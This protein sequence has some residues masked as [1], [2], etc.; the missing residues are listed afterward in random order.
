MSP[1]DRQLLQEAYAS[2]E[3]DRARADA[4]AA[5]LVRRNPDAPEARIAYAAARSRMQDYAAA[6][7]EL[8]IAAC[9]ADSAMLRFNLGYCH[10]QL[11]DYERAAAHLVRGLAMPG[12]DE[13][14]RALAADTLQIL[15]RRDQALSVIGQSDTAITKFCSWLLGATSNAQAREHFDGHPD[16]IDRAVLFWMK[17]DCHLF[18]ELDDKAALARLLGPALGEYWPKA[19]VVPDEIDAAPEDGAWWVFKPAMLA[20]GSG[21]RL[22]RKPRSLPRGTRGIAQ[23]YVHPPFLVEG[24]KMHARL[25]WCLQS[26]DPLRAFLWRDGRVVISPEPYAEPEEGEPSVRHAVNALRAHD[27]ELERPLGR[28]RAH[29]LPLSAVIE[30]GALPAAQ[31]DR[32][33]EAVL[34]VAR[35]VLEALR[36]TGFLARLHAIGNFPP[37]FMGLDVGFTAGLEPRLFEIERYPGMGGSSPARAEMN[38]RFRRQWMAFTLSDQPERDANFA[39]L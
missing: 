24:R 7:R 31:C 5:D 26:V 33:R 12:A 20:G 29:Y 27:D 8:D 38:D 25:L 37:R 15:G 13:T 14:L 32:I 19:Y 30:S 6:A 17:Y 1:A 10:R 36:A 2:L 28:L 23:R 34:E 18:G 22:T 35:A 4:L 21:Q 3:R 9:R 11:G 16:R 39:A